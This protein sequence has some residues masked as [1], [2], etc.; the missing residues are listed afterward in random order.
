MMRL[1]FLAFHFL[2]K[3]SVKEI[4]NIK[5][6]AKT[7]YSVSIHN[8]CERERERKYPNIP[9]Y[10]AF[11]PVDSTIISSETKIGKVPVNKKKKIVNN[12]KFIIMKQRE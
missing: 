7:K 12:Q 11:I 4:I 3:L 5:K 1:F 6:K 10:T 8:L 9:K 2:V